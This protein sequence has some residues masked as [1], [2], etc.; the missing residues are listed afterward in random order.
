MCSRTQHKLTVYV[1]I[2]SNSRVMKIAGWF[3]GRLEWPPDS[4][5]M[6]RIDS[7]SELP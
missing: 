5:D 7:T 2:H 1:T 4:S 3:Q 6:R